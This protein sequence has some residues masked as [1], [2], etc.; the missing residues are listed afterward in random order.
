MTAISLLVFVCILML[1]VIFQVTTIIQLVLLKEEKGAEKS[2]LGMWWQR[3]DR[4]LTDAIPLEKEETIM[5]KHSYDGIH[6]LDN[7]LPPWWLYLFYGTVVFSIVYM[8]NYH[9]LESAPLSTEE[10]NIEVAEAQKQIEAYQKTVAA[11]LNE[12]NVTMV[13]DDA[14]INSGKDLF[15]KN[16]ATCHGQV[17]EGGT[18]PN[19]T[20]AYWIHGGTINDVFKTVKYGVPKQGMIA[21]QKKLTAKDMQ[22]V[23]SYIITLQGTNPPN[24]KEPQGEKMKEK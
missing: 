18:G 22:N 5:F 6:E 19:L 1:V 15:V 16:C 7:H 4:S 12:T 20:D 11:N 21:W 24:A 2:L 13:K 23:S 17:G 10:Y 9:V 3:V 8:I 14:S